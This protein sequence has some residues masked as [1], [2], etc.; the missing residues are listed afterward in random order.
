MGE[1]SWLHYGSA[2]AAHAGWGSQIS[3]HTVPR[4]KLGWY[5][6]TIF[7]TVC[8]TFFFFLPASWK[9]GTT[10]PNAQ[11]ATPSVFLPI[12]SPRSVPTWD[13][14]MPADC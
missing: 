3:H 2:A 5:Y 10:P 7:S 14:Y 1:I 8:F 13:Y 12:R 11:V 4:G 9:L 6:G